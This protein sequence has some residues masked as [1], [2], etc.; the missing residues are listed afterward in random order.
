VTDALDLSGPSSIDGSLIVDR[1]IK[2]TSLSSSTIESIATNEG[3]VW[4]MNELIVLNNL[5]FTNL[6]NVGALYFAGLKGLFSFTFPAFITRATNVT[7]TNTLLQNLDGINLKSVGTLE[8]SNNNR[9]TTL[10]TQLV[11]VTDSITITGNGAGLSVKLPNLELAGDATFRNVSVLQLPSLATVGG[12]FII[13]GTGLTTFSAPNLTDV[14]GS[15]NFA[16]N[17]KLSNLTL[18]ALEIVKGAFTINKT[19]AYELDF[20]SL[21]SVG[22]AIDLIGNFTTYV[23]L[24]ACFTLKANKY[25]LDPNSQS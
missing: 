15:V 1:A 5:S 14:T 18:D 8:V 7:I 16:D 4:R 11:N 2:L 9:L 22:G 12:S 17:P 25:T 3:A 24:I 20:P 19:L 10:S 21:A 6:T 13:A 23:F